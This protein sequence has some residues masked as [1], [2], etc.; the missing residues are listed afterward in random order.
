V[1]SSVLREE[2]H[3]LLASEECLSESHIQLGA[4]YVS[5]KNISKTSASYLLLPPFYHL[6]GLLLFGRTEAV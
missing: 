2:G 1:Q 6:S 5:Y 4:R 3:D